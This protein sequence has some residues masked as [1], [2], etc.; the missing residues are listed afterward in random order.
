L[1]SASPIPDGFSGDG[2]RRNLIANKELSP[3]SANPAHK[4]PQPKTPVCFEMPE[5]ATDCHTHIH[6][7]P[8]RFPW[9]E[10]RV[11]TPETAFPE[12][13]AG[14]HGKLGIRRV[15]VVTPSV[16]GTDN[17]A[18]AWGMKALG[19]PARGVAVID[20][21]T[22]EAELDTLHYKGFRGIRLNLAT[23]GMNDAGAARARLVAAV[24]RMSH[25]GWHVQIYTTLD[26]VAQLKDTIMAS[27]VP[28]VLDHFAGARAV[29]GTGQPGFAELCELL[30]AGGTYVKISGAYRASDKDPGFPDVMPLAQA[31]IAAN[32]DRIVWGTDWPHPDSHTM[33]PMTA[34]DVRPFYDIDD[35]ALLNQ[36]A[37]WAPDEP[38]RKKILADNPARLY[39][40]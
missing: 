22:S 7:A 17:R 33:P 27:P 38:I 18:T 32:E 3:M 9:F 13:M 37:T 30:R 29:L 25:R 10:G 40:F 14:L 1:L 15:V 21:R 26:M 19:Y 16:Y 31:M 4:A 5:G 34:L 28:I 23:S 8:A 12:E 24:Q 35:G 6:G 11:Y 20:D 39:G 36:L 2:G